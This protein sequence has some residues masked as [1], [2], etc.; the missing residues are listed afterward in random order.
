MDGD[1]FG[2]IKRDEADDGRKGVDDTFI[3]LLPLPL[4]LLL[5]LPLLP[6]EVVDDFEG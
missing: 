4:P 2:G 3:V 1:A 5:L 6:V